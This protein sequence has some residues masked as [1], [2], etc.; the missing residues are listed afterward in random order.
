VVEVVHTHPHDRPALLL[1]HPG[2]R[3]GERRLARAV[4]PVDPD[5]YAVL[6]GRRRDQGHDPVDR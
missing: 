5:P 2:Q 6:A 3:V 4:H 1:E